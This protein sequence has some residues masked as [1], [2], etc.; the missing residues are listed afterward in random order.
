MHLARFHPPARQTPDTTVSTTSP[1]PGDMPRRRRA[2]LADAGERLPRRSVV[3]AQLGPRLCRPA[4]HAVRAGGNPLAPERHVSI[5]GCVWCPHLD[6]SWAIIGMGLPTFTVLAWEAHWSHAKVGAEAA[7]APPLQRCACVVVA[8]A[9]A[10][11]GLITPLIKRLSSGLL[12][13]S[14]I[15][16]SGCV[17]T[18]RPSGVLSIAVPPGSDE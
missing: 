15:V 17:C 7:R 5:A 9:H 8:C 6:R 4:V 2:L 12:S 16:P 1:R 14:I 3:A 13:S 11:G 18:F 10:P